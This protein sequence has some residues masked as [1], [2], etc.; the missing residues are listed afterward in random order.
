MENQKECDYNKYKV[1]KKL[2]PYYDLKR[3]FTVDG[4]DDDNKTVYH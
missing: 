3:P 2:C 1:G 4:Y